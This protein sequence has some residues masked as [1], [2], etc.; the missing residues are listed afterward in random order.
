M[1]VNCYVTV[2]EHNRVKRNHFIKWQIE[3]K[4]ALV[5]F[6]PFLTGC[7]DYLVARTKNGI[8]WLLWTILAADLRKKRGEIHI[9][10]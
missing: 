9:L 10:S 4:F 8:K 7:L 2:H 1:R 5:G 6:T 3:T